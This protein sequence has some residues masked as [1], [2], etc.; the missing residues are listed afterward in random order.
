MLGR[1]E[2]HRRRARA[3]GGPV[4]VPIKPWAVVPAFFVTGVLRPQPAPFSSQ[5]EPGKSRIAAE[6]PTLISTE[7][8]GDCCPH[9]A[10]IS[11]TGRTSITP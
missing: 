4:N 6:N 1:R 11:T 2:R 9:A 5:V 7:C 3:G 10:H 8:V